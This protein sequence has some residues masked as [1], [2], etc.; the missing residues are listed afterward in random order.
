MTVSDGQPLSL[1]A[2]DGHGLAWQFLFSASS[3]SFRTM[4]SLAS[5]TAERGLP[6]DHRTAD[7]PHGFDQSF[8]TTP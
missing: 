1:T 5:P 8:G 3:V 4:A 2:S 7:L 6:S